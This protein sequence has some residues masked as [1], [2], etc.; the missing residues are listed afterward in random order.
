[1][2]G[3]QAYS[4]SERPTSLSGV[5]N[6]VWIRT[7]NR[8]MRMGIWTTRGPIQPMGLTPASRY[9][10]MVSCDTLARSLE[11]RSLISCILGWR[12]LIARIWRTC[13]RVS[14]RVARRTRTVN[15]T[16]ANPIWLKL[17][18]YNTSKVLSIGRMMNSV[19]RKAIASKRLYSLG[20]YSWGLY[21]W[22]IYSWGIYSL[23]AKNRSFALDIILGVE[24][25]YWPAKLGAPYVKSPYRAVLGP[26][27]HR[28]LQRNSS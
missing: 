16:M 17:M 9:N 8:P 21:S 13:L 22:G 12:E 11:Y 6:S 14:G 23:R 15:K 28:F 4:F 1:M 10:R 24:A 19:Q 3:I 27:E 25:P 2:M 26:H 18:T 20:L 7:R 5:L